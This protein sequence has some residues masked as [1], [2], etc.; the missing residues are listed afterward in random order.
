MAY[1]GLCHVVIVKTQDSKEARFASS[2]C[3]G[4]YVILIANITIKSDNLIEKVHLKIFHLLFGS[5]FAA[6][7]SL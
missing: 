4:L 5:P 1:G 2:A 6:I 3:C 7:D